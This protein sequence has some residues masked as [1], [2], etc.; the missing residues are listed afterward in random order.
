VSRTLPVFFK[1]EGRPCLVV[2]G[3]NIA[4]EKT[5]RL[6]DAGAEVTMVAPDIAE[7]PS[8]LK[9]ADVRYVRRGYR[10]GDIDG[11]V[12]VIAATDDPGVQRS[13][14]DDARGRGTPV[15]VVDQPD[16]CD[17]IFGAILR[18]GDLQIAVSTGGRFPLLASKLRD[19]LLDVFPFETAS[20][21]EELG[22]VRDEV[23]KETAGDIP[24]LREILGNLLTPEIV[25]LIERG[26]IDTLRERIR[27]W[28][29]SATV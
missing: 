12:L 24:R 18:R 5:E 28:S 21:I 15:N 29:S 1:L 3:G 10:A 14:F 4:W 23:R 26:D 11:H 17:F 7:A 22:R 16:L 20:A 25:Q 9:S 8:R 6:L 27:A 19:R 13:V 2:G